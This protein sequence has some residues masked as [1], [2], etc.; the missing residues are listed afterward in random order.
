MPATKTTGQGGDSVRPCPVVVV[1][2]TGEVPVSPPRPMM[3]EQ[4][5]NSGFTMPTAQSPAST[6]DDP[7]TTNR[8]MDRRISTTG[9]RNL[10]IR[11][12]LAVASPT[13]HDPGCA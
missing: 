11:C 2:D 6:H 13:R 10:E 4:Q 5:Q 1:G 9:D 12:D 3:F 8:E 7:E